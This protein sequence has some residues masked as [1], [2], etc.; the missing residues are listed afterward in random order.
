MLLY[1]VD[2]VGLLGF[3]TACFVACCS[4]QQLVATRLAVGL[5]CGLSM[6]CIWLWAKLQQGGLHGSPCPIFSVFIFILFTRTYC[7]SLKSVRGLLL[8]Q[9]LIGLCLVMVRSNFYPA[10]SISASRLH[11]VFIGAEENAAE[12]IGFDWVF[13]I[14]WTLVYLVWVESTE[15]A[16]KSTGSKWRSTS[17]IFLLS[18][19]L[20]LVDFDIDF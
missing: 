16:F 1:Q 17:G 15:V 10:I 12:I 9:L 19:F 3:A 5:A 8:V 2:I 20:F 11:L 4:R 6:L 18:F 7:P 13:G 14:T